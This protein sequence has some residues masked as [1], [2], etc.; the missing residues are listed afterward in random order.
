MQT[1][2]QLPQYSIILPQGTEIMSSNIE[3]GKDKFTAFNKQLNYG[4]KINF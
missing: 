4:W 2:I 1:I 3:N